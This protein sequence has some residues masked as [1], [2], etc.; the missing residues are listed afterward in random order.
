MGGG[1]IDIGQPGR[2]SILDSEGALLYRMGVSFGLKWVDG[3]PNDWFGTTATEDKHTY[4]AFTDAVPFDQIPAIWKKKFD[5]MIEG[6]ASPTPSEAFNDLV[7][8][9]WGAGAAAE[10]GALNTRAG[11]TDSRVSD[12]LYQVLH[13]QYLIKHLED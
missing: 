10:V 9:L 4:A 12:T 13:E 6:A 5:L 1:I 3:E 11:F 8:E 7:V 2:E